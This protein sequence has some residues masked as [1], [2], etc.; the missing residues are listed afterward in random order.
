MNE[1]YHHALKLL[2]RKDYTQKQLREKLEEKFGAVP[3]DVTRQL[4]AKRFLND[5]RYADNFAARSTPIVIRIGFEKLFRRPAL[6]GQSSNLR[7]LPATGPRFG[8]FS[9]L[10]CSFGICARHLKD[11]TCSVFFAF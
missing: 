11:G 9:R 10:K 4:L 3:D 1:I 5:Q 6:T 2:R 8:K 7:L